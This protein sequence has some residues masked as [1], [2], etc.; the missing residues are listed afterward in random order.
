MRLQGCYTLLSLSD[1]LTHWLTDLHNWRSYTFSTLQEIIFHVLAAVK[2]LLKEA[3]AVSGWTDNNHTHCCTALHYSVLYCTAL[4]CTILYCTVLYCT[5]L[6]C[7]AL[8]CTVLYCTVLYCTVLFSSY[9]FLFLN[10]SYI[11]FHFHL[12]S[13]SFTFFSIYPSIHLYSPILY[14][15]L[16]PTFYLTLSPTF[17]TPSPTPFLTGKCEYLGADQLFPLLV[18][19]LIH[20]NI[21][22][23]Q[24]V[25]VRTYCTYQ[26]LF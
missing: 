20:S 12:L 16:S 19:I 9:L 8:Y 21:P 6:Y 1:S 22:H 7:T 13:F 3:G 26:L 10:F 15:T 4:C 18:G 14:H 25:L 2:W 24:L 23:M 17:P 11:Y 5:V